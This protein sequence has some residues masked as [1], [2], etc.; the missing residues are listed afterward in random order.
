MAASLSASTGIHHNIKNVYTFICL[1]FGNPDDEIYLI[2]FSRGAY[3][4][5]CLAAL[6]GTIGLLTKAGLVHIN[7]LYKGWSKNQAADDSM[8]VRFES[9][10]AKME[11]DNHLRRRINI[12]ACAVWD[13]V[14]AIGLPRILTDMGSYLVDMIPAG[15]LLQLIP[16]TN[17]SLVYNKL[18]F[19]DES[20][21]RTLK[22]AF[23][24]L[25]L[26]EMRTDFKPVFW[27]NPPDT[28]VVKQCWFL[29]SHSDVGGGY[30]DAGLANLTLVWM[31]AQLRTYTKLGISNEALRD[32]LTPRGLSNPKAS[33]FALH[34]K[35]G[36]EKHNTTIIRGS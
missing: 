27:A 29:G 7:T 2:G 24:A 26:N 9:M 11:R 15:Q 36:C 33:H 35:K 4:A 28:T 6:I 22:N 25:A 34:E 21:P 14:S 12:E 16:N 19:I 20:I 13:T 10:L 30:A 18:A 31:I 3:T 32:Y 5:R 23:Q 8:G 17:A 1:N